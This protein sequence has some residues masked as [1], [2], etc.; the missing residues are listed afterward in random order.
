MGGN[1]NG[2]EARPMDVSPEP[3]LEPAPSLAASPRTKTSSTRSKGIQPTY[4]VLLSDQP[5]Y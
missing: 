1:E 2:L 5:D 4:M 3:T